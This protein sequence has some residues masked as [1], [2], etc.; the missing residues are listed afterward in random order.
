M[1]DDLKKLAKIVCSEIS[2]GIPSQTIL[3]Y[4]T[5]TETYYYDRPY[6]VSDVGRCVYLLSFFPEWKEKIKHISE[7]FPV[8]GLIGENWAEI[9]KAYREKDRLKIHEL[10]KLYAG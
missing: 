2:L 10:L 8:W 9:E 5:E 3:A 7:R 4:C 1:S 6:D